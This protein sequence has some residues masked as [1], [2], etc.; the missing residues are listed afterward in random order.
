MD[1]QTTSL[2]RPARAGSGGHS[3]VVRPHRVGQ[4][5]R[6]RR[7]CPF[8]ARGPPADD[9]VIPGFERIAQ[10][11]HDAGAL[12]VQQFLHAGRYGGVDRL[13]EGRVIYAGRFSEQ[14]LVRGKRVV[15]IGGERAGLGVAARAGS[16]APVP[17]AA[18]AHPT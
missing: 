8:A 16:H 17:A 11:I 1:R 13:E 12:A 10:M 18:A 7:V 9:R 15:A 14:Q 4:R 6:R 3:T 2:D 5:A